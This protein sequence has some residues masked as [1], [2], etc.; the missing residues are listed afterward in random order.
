MSFYAVH[1]GLKPGV[2]KT[3]SECEEQVK[4]FKGS[5]FRKFSS[6]EEAEEFSKNGGI[7]ESKEKQSKLSFSLKR[8]SSEEQQ[9]ENQPPKKKKEDEILNIYCDGSAKDNGKPNCKAGFA[10]FFGKGD[11]R[12]FS[13]EFYDNPTN[14][15]AELYGILKSLEIIIENG[16]IHNHKE[17]IIH[18]DSEYSINCV[19]RWVIGWKKNAWKTQKNTPVENQHLIKSIDTLLLKHKHVSLHH[20]PAHTN[21]K[22]IHSINNDYVDKMAKQSYQ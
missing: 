6:L 21:E 11:K 22:D 20:V 8:K 16:D 17:I 9:D 10:V 18:S 5:V 7:E 19:T 12:N 1:K 3:W 2:F 15:R 4:G 13:Q 14:N